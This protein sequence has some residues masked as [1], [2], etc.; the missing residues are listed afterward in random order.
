MNSVGLTLVVSFLCILLTVLQI[1]V[2]PLCSLP[3][4][5]RSAHQG[6]KHARAHNQH[7]QLKAHANTY[8][9][10][11]YKSKP[12]TP[13]C[14]M[15]CATRTHAH[16]HKLD[17]RE[18]RTEMLFVNNLEKAAIQGYSIPGRISHLICVKSLYETKQ[19]MA[20]TIALSSPQCH[21]HRLY[22]V[23]CLCPFVCV[24]CCL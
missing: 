6:N 11:P 3:F 23:C 2:V 1:P 16:M 9:K 4:L 7:T 20:A 5:L 13:E 10:T 17:R 19:V 21:L 24:E 15:P 12:L 22:A 14:S 18:Q 8:I